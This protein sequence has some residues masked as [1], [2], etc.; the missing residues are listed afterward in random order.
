MRIA[1]V[2][3]T[4]LPSADGI[5][6]RVLATIDELRR[7]GHEILV[8]APRTPEPE[9]AGVL[10]R[11]VPTIRFG[12]V[13]GGQRWGLPL[14]RV[15][16]YLAEFGPD[17]VHVLNPV[18][19]GAAGAVSARAQGV[20]LIASHH[21]DL[22]RYAR[23]YQ[24]SWIVPALRAHQ[25]RLHGLAHVNLATSTTGREQLHANRI[26]N[27]GLWPAGVDQ[28]AYRPADD[29]AEGGGRRRPTALYVGRIAAEK[30]LHRLAPLAG[31][32]SPY[33]LMIVGDGRRAP[34]S[35]RGSPTG[36]DSPVH[37][38]ALPW[39]RPI[40]RPTSSCSRRRPRPWDLCCWRPWPA[41]CRWS[42]ST[43]RRAVSCCET[44]W[45]PGWCRRTAR[46][47]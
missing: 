25:R 18:L 22:V 39:P 23:D 46:I 19:I 17:V 27:V 5:I 21:T 35:R 24:L 28:T 42:P 1:F 11:T 44:A 31:P 36:S 13:Y 37:C 34:T 3:E 29:A 47:S 40:G 43:A 12:W 33:D 15:A 26:T 4:W 30:E 38:P 20:P 2:T 16:R 41:G 6:T 32:D 7:R 10:V 45:R 8:V 9:H 14:P